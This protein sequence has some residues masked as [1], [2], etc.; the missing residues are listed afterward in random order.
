MG[1][2]G[3][4]QRPDRGS[5]LFDRYRFL[6]RGCLLV[7]EGR[8]A[9]LDVRLTAPV[10]VPVVHAHGGTVLPGLIDAHVHLFPGA[11]QSALRSRVTTEL[12]L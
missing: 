12:D 7:L 11:L 5:N 10:G 3:A 9:A 4:G 1:D 8:V 2:R 6:P